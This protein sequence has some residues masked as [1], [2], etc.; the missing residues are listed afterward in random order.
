MLCLVLAGGAVGGLLGC[1][2]TSGTFK[3][4]PQIVMELTPQQ[5]QTLYSNL[6]VFMGDIQWTEVAQLIALVMG[7]A[8]LK[9]QLTGALVGYVT[10]ELQAKVHYVD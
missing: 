7:N 4:L 8:T 6:M 1:W 10:K 9:Q 3:P 5:Q 2:L